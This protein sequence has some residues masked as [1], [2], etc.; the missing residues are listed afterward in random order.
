[1]K[2]IQTNAEKLIT[3]R[4]S[5]LRA[6]GALKRKAKP[7]LP[8]RPKSAKIYEVEFYRLIKNAL[9]PYRQAIED[10][11]LPALPLIIEA[12]K[13]QIR[14]DD[15]YGEVVST[16]F[17]GIEIGVFISLSDAALETNLLPFTARL[18]DFNKKEFGRQIFS[19]VG[20]NPLTTEKYLDPKVKSF[21][22]EN[23]ALIKN[24]PAESK[25]KLE[26]KIRR[27]IESGES[28][29][30]ITATVKDEIAI[31]DN[32]AKLIARDQTNKF[33]GS[34]TALRQTELGIEQYVWMT[35][36]DERVRGRPGGKYPDAR[37]SH[38]SRQG[39]KFSWDKPPSGGHPGFA[40]QCRCVAVPVLDKYF[41]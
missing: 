31:V 26:G 27:G 18:A 39:K 36:N 6:A 21:I 12:Y 8:A 22:A 41:E 17:E 7:R 16:A 2:K 4:R 32:R 11:L 20:V 34:L 1:M 38:W 30:E 40:I 9:S 25:R 10:K 23:I 15:A 33:L 35:S 5:S 28:L 29:V 14:F 37:P 13:A 3:L 24:I 19:V